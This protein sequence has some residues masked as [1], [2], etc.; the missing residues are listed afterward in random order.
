MHSLRTICPRFAVAPRFSPTNY[1]TDT[2][3]SQMVQTKLTF[4]HRITPAGGILPVSFHG[5]RGFAGGSASIVRARAAK[6]NSRTGDAIRCIETTML[7]L[8]VFT[9]LIFGT[10]ILA[11]LLGGYL[12]RG[13]G[14][15]PPRGVSKI[16]IG[17]F[18]GRIRDVGPFSY[19]CAT[20]NGILEL[21][22]I[23]WP[24]GD[25]GVVAKSGTHADDRMST[26]GICGRT[27]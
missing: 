12:L 7:S 22:T 20:V 27:R 1:V 2:T 10:S 5:P 17:M 14:C 24:T 18:L 3:Y 9:W 23:I 26:F 19:F 16:R 8:M 11:G 15:V 13:C 4:C 6:V 21:L 25:N